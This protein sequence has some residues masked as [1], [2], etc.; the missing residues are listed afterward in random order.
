M[1][2]SPK[3]VRRRRNDRS[4]LSYSFLPEGNRPARWAY[5]FVLLGLIPGLGLI[6]SLPAIVLGIVGRRVALKDEHKRGIGHAWA[7]R[8]L[9]SFEL[10]CNGA[11]V[12]CLFKAFGE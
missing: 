9:G 5:I 11:G 8:V 1:S 10:L 2:A 12:Y 3:K 4:A 7:G 6:F